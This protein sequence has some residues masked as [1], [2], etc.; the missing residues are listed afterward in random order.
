M[1]KLGCV[2]LA[3]YILAS[4]FFVSLAVQTSSNFKS[5]AI[6]LFLPVGFVP[7]EVFGLL[8]K[9]S[10]ELYS[11]KERFLIELASRYPIGIAFMCIFLYALGWAVS[12]AFK[13]NTVF[14]Y[15][16]TLV[17]VGGYFSG[18]FIF[19]KDFFV[20]LWPIFIIFGCFVSWRN[21]SRVKTVN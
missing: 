13:T 15:K 12:I 6:A 3:C 8:P 11:G 20:W 4:T 18:C 14:G 5:L 21:Y 19:G 10:S 16:F 1:S 17:L 2:F 7:V 9:V